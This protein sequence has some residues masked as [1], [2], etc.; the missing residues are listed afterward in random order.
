MK[1]AELTWPDVENASRE[2]VVVIPTGS[3][4]QH[5]PHLPL[6]T[7]TLIVTAVAEA[8]EAQIPNY[9]LLTPTLWLGASLHHLPFAGSLSASFEA[10]GRALN[11]VI[12]SLMP[13]GF[14][15]FLVL[16]GHGG[17]TSPND[18]VLRDLKHRNPS[19]SFGH[20]GYHDLCAPVTAQV[21]TGR[22]KEMAHACEAETSLMLH[23]HPALVHLDRARN[24]GLDADPPVVSPVHQ[25]DEITEVGSFGYPE[26]GTKEKGEAIF[27][28]A[29]A[30]VSEEIQR[31]ASGY[32]LSGA[33]W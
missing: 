2:I 11:D 3:L 28:A 6:F 32:A 17:N 31:L 21:S 22:I 4:E 14:R 16:N 20:V 13:H 12:A 10:Y 29:V 25:F 15:K 26:L 27:Q 8:V 33:S 30:A 9:C 18:I 24:G 1:L 23:L 7:D 5:G 19:A